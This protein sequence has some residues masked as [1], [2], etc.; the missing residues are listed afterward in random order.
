MD[1]RLLKEDRRH[2]TPQF[3][4]AVY[5]MD[6]Q[7]GVVLDNHWHDEVE[8][9]WVVEGEATFQIGMADYELKAGEAIF[10]PGGEVHGGFSSDGSAC[11]YRAMVFHLDWLGDG[12]DNISSL[13]IEPL[14]TE[15]RKFRFIMTDRQCGEDGFW[16]GWPECF[17]YTSRKLWR[18]NCEL[19]PN[20]IP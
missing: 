6:C 2:G 18:E 17:V 10:V 5:A 4:F 3:P 8:F 13:F 1:L 16:S 12:L 11:S 9:L 19:K 20:F 15:K 14:K 7:A